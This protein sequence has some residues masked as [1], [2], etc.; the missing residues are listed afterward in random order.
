MVDAGY[1][2]KTP[3]RRLMKKLMTTSDVRDLMRREIEKAGSVQAWA[4]TVGVSKQYISKVLSGEKPPSGRILD[5][6]RIAEAGMT[7]QRI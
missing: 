3:A 2:F 1:R 7:Y 6:L 5:V 4:E